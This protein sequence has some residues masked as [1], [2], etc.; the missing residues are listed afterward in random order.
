MAFA[1][2][3]HLS[4]SAVEYAVAASASS[5]TDGHLDQLLAPLTSQPWSKI[6]ASSVRSHRNVVQ[7][8]VLKTEVRLALSR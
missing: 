6:T 3:S 5:S 8:D 2:P 1:L 7:K 4:P